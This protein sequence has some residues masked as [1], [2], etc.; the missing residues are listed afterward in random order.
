MT[1]PKSGYS[2]GLRLLTAAAGAENEEI[3]TRLQ[4]EST[5]HFLRHAC[6]RLDHMSDTMDEILLKMN[7]NEPSHA[8]AVQ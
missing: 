8:R 1:N 7:E 6:E 2:I 4:Q 5:H 3:K